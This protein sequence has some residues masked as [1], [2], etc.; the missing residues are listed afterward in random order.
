VHQG[1]IKSFDNRIDTSSGTIRAR[2]YF[3]NEGGT[4][5]PGMFVTVRLGSPAEENVILLTEQAISTDQDRKFVYVVDET[6]KVAYREVTLGAAVGGQRVI[7]SGL[8][9]GEQVIIEGIM[10]I[11]P[12]MT[13]S[14]QIAAVDAPEA[15]ALLPPPVI[16]PA[17]QEVPMEEPVIEEIMIEEPATEIPAEAP[18]AEEAPAPT[19]LLPAADETLK[20]EPPAE[21]PPAE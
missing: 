7:T 4:L 6:G 9:P 19:S 12:G 1:Y 16:E 13:V 11:Q 5:L 15:E 14:P 21:A 18:I 3:E 17:A 10:K 20:A 2:A 8:Q